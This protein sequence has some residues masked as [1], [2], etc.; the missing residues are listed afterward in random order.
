LPLFLRLAAIVL[1]TVAL[2]RPQQGK[3]AIK[4]VSEGVAIEMV[5]DRS[6]SMEQEFMYDESRLSRLEAVKT[7]FNLFALGDNQNLRGRPN[8]LIGI[9]TF[10]R[11]ADTICPLTLS[12]DILPH[13]V[14]AI[15][16]ETRKEEDGTAIGDGLALAAARLKSAEAQL[17]SV[18]QKSG[19][20]AS[21]WDLQSKPHGSGYKIKSKVIVLLTD[22]QN[23]AGN[24]TPLEAARTAKDWGVKIYAI[25]IGGKE[26]LMTIDTPFGEQEVQGGPGV[27]EET[28]KAVAAETG[29]AYWP[30]ES[31][32]KLRSIY[33]EI[34]RLEKS[35]I[36]SFS[37]A[38]YLERFTPF[39]IAALVTIFLEQLLLSTLLR[40]I[41]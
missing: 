40:R 35:E 34:D 39:A 4:D 27:D 23:N 5:V 17:N 10:A 13:F 16:L 30:A 7:I 36:E 11:Y 2:A 14:S 9:V 15:K 6:S 8:D 29:G 32:D 33:E 25:G 37:Y 22:G 18:S 12:H 38:D 28:L 20:A 41:P 21:F 3:G 24:R 26:S 1:L 31:G 19:K